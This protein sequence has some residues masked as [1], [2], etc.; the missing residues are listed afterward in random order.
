VDAFHFDVSVSVFVCSF[1][2]LHD[3][4]HHF[5]SII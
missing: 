1:L 3:H 4:A 5:F 2:M